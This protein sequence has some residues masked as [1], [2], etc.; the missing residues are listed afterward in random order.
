MVTKILTKSFLV[1]LRVHGY[2]MI[3]CDVNLT[4]HSLMH[5]EYKCFGIS[6]L[7]VIAN[8]IKALDRF[9]YFYN[10]QQ[11]CNDLTWKQ[12]VFRLLT[13]LKSVLCEIEMYC[14]LLYAN[15]FS[16]FYSAQTKNIVLSNAPKLCGTQVPPIRQ[17]V[18]ILIKCKNP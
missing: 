1:F 8:E 14:F 3:F 10:A 4:V 17:G 12:R 18:K 9:F 15:S 7:S 13:A 2:L 16:Y 6:R 5:K 11:Q